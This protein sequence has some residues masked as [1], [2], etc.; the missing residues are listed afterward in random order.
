MSDWLGKHE[1]VKCEGYITVFD[2]GKGILSYIL[3][4]FHPLL[5]HT[6]FEEVRFV[7]MCI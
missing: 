1:H 7:I 3:I 5:V 2:T 4:L 6:V